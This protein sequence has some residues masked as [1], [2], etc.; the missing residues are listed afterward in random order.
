MEKSIHIG[1]IVL[2]ICSSIH[3]VKIIL[4]MLP[5]LIQCLLMGNHMSNAIS[6]LQE[7]DYF[8]DEDS[9]NSGRKPKKKIELELILLCLRESMVF[10]A[11]HMFPFRNR[12]LYHTV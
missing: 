7:L 11:L 12:L 10:F 5:L 4:P 6:I 9:D 8:S 2:R 1:Y 3:A